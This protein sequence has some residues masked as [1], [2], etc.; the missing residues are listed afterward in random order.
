MDDQLLV[1]LIELE[2]E[3]IVNIVAPED[4]NGKPSAK[5]HESQSCQEVISVHAWIDLLPQW[6]LF[7]WTEDEEEEEWN[8]DGYAT[9][10]VTQ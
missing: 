1:N 3:N 4:L 8:H 7:W 6:I 2:N 9:T 10:V 5:K